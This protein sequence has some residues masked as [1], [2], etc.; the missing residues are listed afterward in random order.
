MSLKEGTKAPTFK[1]QAEHAGQWIV[2]YFY[3]KDDTPGCTR[4]ACGFQDL[5]KI[6]H[7]HNAV[8][9]G[10]SRDDAVSH[11]GFKQKYKLSFPLLSDPDLNLHKAY[12]AWADNKVI[13]STFLIDPKGNIAKIWPNIKVDGHVE[14]VLEAIKNAEGG[15]R[16][17]TR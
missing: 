13:R 14:K 2:L 17:R 11:E 5:S 9:F 15:T 4:E 3:P 7:E 6:F 12:G 1:E 16:T 10:V 8:I